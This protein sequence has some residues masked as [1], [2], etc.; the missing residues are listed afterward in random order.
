MTRRL[1]IDD[2]TDL[3]VPSQP[4]LSPDGSRVAY[5]LRT[6]DAEQDR[7]VD[8]LWLVDA[9]GGAAHRLTAG[10]A[11]TSPAWSPDGGRVA[12]V[13]A[14]QLAVLDAGG[15]EAITLTELPLG[16]GAPVW[17]PDGR[18]LAFTAPVDPTGSQG[19]TAPMVSETTDYQADGAGI[20]GSVRTQLHVVDVEGRTVRQLTDGPDH[21]GSPAWSPDGSTIAFTAFRGAAGDPPFRLPL[22]LLDVEDPHARPRLLAFAAGLVAAATWAPDGASLLAVAYPG[23]PVGHTHLFRVSIVDGAY[24]DLSGPLDR[25]V[26]AGAPAYPGGLPVVLDGRVWFCVRDRGCT[27]LWSVAADGSDARPVL[28]GAGR[29][30]SGLSVA[31][32]RAAVVLATPASYG[33]VATSPYDAGVALSLIH[34]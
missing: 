22:H 14:G 7:N 26:M 30:V 11:D 21:V 10:P 5:V 15:G 2:L 17:S 6:L 20:L 3:A 19:G 18:R 23:D 34:I 24:E 12:F 13:R 25:N 9:S 8:E 4:A 16:A 32:G 33:E 29:V 31:S 27:H 1:R 28:D